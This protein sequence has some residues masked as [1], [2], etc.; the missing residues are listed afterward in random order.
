MHSEASTQC[1]SMTP[2]MHCTGSMCKGGSSF[3]HRLVPYPGTGTCKTPCTA[4]F[5]MAGRLCTSR[6]KACCPPYELDEL[7]AVEREVDVQIRPRVRTHCLHQRGCMLHTHHI[8]L[9]LSNLILKPDDSIIEGG[10]EMS[11]R[12]LT[13]NVHDMSLIASCL[14]LTGWSKNSPLERKQR[15]CVGMHACLRSALAAS[16]R[17]AMRCARTACRHARVASA[18][19]SST[20]R[21]LPQPNQRGHILEVLPTPTRFIPHGA[22]GRELPQ[23]DA[24]D[25]PRNCFSLTGPCRNRWMCQ[26]AAT[27]TGIAGTQ[28]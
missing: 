10:H 17:P 18:A 21:P 19:F 15:A 28:Q 9:R 6:V 12:V 4:A 8:H 2:R 22:S 24:H 25:V 5:G 11:I 3:L 23:Q 7:E 14:I 1:Q 13:N 27:P 16:T 20:P 26:A